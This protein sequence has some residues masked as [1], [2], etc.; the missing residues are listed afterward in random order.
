MAEA[1]AVLGA[2]AATSQLGQQVVNILSSVMTLY[3]EFQNAQSNHSE[4][5][6]LVKNIGA[7]SSINHLK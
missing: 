3:N 2:V 5:F 1:L 4:I 6:R 7:V